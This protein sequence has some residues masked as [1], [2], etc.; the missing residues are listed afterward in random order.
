MTLLHDTP[1]IQLFGQVAMHY[2]IKY[3]KPSYFSGTV[4]L[5]I[6]CMQGFSNLHFSDFIEN[7]LVTLCIYAYI[8][9]IN[10]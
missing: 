10:F 9:H 6:I 4:I 1:F 7:L 3:L 2:H 8:M 5:A